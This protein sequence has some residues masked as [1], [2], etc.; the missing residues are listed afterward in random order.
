[1]YSHVYGVK[2]S[3]WSVPFEIDYL[4]EGV[5][6]FSNIP[7]P[8]MGDW[9]SRVFA[10]YCPFF[11]FESMYSHVYGVMECPFR[12]LLFKGGGCEFSNIPYPFFP[13]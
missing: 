6:E 12:N 1:M 10:V 2:W 13:N 4:R 5:C 11:L 8:L 3:P 7:Y 9:H